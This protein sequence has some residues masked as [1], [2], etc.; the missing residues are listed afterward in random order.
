LYALTPS[1]SQGRHTIN[2]SKL[3]TY[4]T[5]TDPLSLS[6]S[7]STSS[8]PATI[9][10]ADLMKSISI[11]TLTSPS[12][13]T[14]SDEWALTEVARHF[15]TLWSS[16]VT[17]V[18][19]N[20]WLAADMEGNLVVLR[21]NM[22]GVTEDDKRRLEV[23]SEGRLGE[24]VNTIVPVH[25]PSAPPARERAGPTTTVANGSAHPLGPAVVPKAF[26]ATVEGGVYMLGS[27]SSSFQDLLMRLQNAI[28]GRIEAPGYMP[29]AKYRAFKTEVREADEP[30]RFVDGEL[31]EMVLGLDDLVVE[32]VCK[33][34]GAGL[35]VEGLRAMVEGLRR[36]H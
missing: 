21:R 6:V 28:A 17:C 23:V 12:S 14:S 34:L 20:E 8:Q 19:E 27:I 4:R 9:A 2:L 16:A 1:T 25:V 29:W 22:G 26:L 15:A 7:P 18:G 32:D 24:V 33:E 35:T 5:S 13:T 36:L 10:V 30:Y 3:A 11:L 31:I